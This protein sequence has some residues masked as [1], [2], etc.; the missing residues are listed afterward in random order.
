[1]LQP[2]HPRMVTSTTPTSRALRALALLLCCALWPLCAL[3][4]DGTPA[5]VEPAPVEI[6]PGTQDSMAAESDRAEEGDDLE[7]G[8][9]RLFARLHPAA[10][11]FPIG[12]IA[13]AAFFE[14]LAVVRPQRRVNSPESGPSPRQVSS[15][16]VA[17]L[18]VGALSAALSAW[19]GWEL[20]EHEPPGSSLAGILLWHRWIGV[21]VACLALGAALLGQVGR[22]QRGAS[23]RSLYRLILFPTAGLTLW[24]G[25][26]GGSMVYG[27]DYYWSVFEEKSAA[28][29][30][31]QSVPQPSVLDQQ[32]APPGDGAGVLAVDFQT[33]IEPI[34]TQSCVECH[35]PNRKRGKL[36]VDSLDQIAQ[37]LDVL[38]PGNSAQSDLIRRLK[39]DPA[40]A[41]FMPRDRDP[42]TPAQIDLIARWIDSWDGS[43]V[44]AAP[45]AED[46]GAATPETTQALV[47]AG[48]PGDKNAKVVSADSAVK[49]AAEDS[50]DDAALA[51]PPVE[52]GFEIVDLSSA[53]Q[54]ALA[55]AMQAVNA[56]GAS[57]VF[58]GANSEAVDVNLSV[59]G[60]T[61]S[62]ADLALLSGLEPRLRWLNLA[63]LSIPDTAW[64]ELSRYRELRRLDV[65]STGVTDS[66][67][68]HIASLPK[69]V[70]LNLVGNPLTDASA[71][72]LESIP[73]L[74]RVYLWQTGLTDSALSSLAAAR[75]DLAIIGAA[76]L[77][78]VPPEQAAAPVD[79]AAQPECCKAALAAG[80]TCDHP[81]CVEAAA[82]GH[83]CAKCLGG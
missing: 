26:L 49:T 19:T 80:K 16:A 79:P 38:S 54:A 42:L 83:V 59:L 12:L 71:R 34:F 43:V 81:C 31:A 47:D 10:V 70:S 55:S 8:W 11:H 1:M 23:F 61:F 44:G 57:A 39:L 65:R 18:T 48:T 22:M 62:P 68:E 73:S 5:E 56:R 27:E 69:L 53:Q 3:A 33:E 76:T 72:V 24:G 67:L 41:D 50:E 82:A 37:R 40:N 29:P 52:A 13:T 58:I 28:Q 74:Q 32:P 17:C 4:Q 63:G 25:H 9:E 6:A 75:P 2:V 7:S 77:P 35:G 20:A 46:R 51:Q 60:T 30:P 66:A 78:E 36:R 14:L 64:R 45:L 15:T 21:A